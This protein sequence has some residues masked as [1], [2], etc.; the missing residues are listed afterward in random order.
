MARRPRC[1][2]CKKAFTPKKRGRPPKYCCA[3]HRQRAYVMWPPEQARR[4]SLLLGRDID[5]YRTKA[6]IER[7]VLA[8]LRKFGVLPPEPKKP[9]P[10]KLVPKADKGER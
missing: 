8:A 5:E 10:L 6:G 9:P 1:K 2:Y 4:M 7:A 3:A